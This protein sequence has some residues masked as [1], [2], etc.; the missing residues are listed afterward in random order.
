[1]K[2]II[3]EK[4][5]VAKEIAHIVG[6]DK[7]EEGYMQGNG[8]YVTWAFGHLVQPAMPDTYGMKGFHAENLPVIPDPF[9]LVP[10]QVKTE[11][12]YKPDAG[13]LAQI[14]IIGKL[15]DSSERIIVATD[16]GREGELIFRYLY[17]YLGCRKPFDRLWISSLT[18]TAIREGLLNLRDGKEYDNLYHAAKARSEADWLVGING[19]Q[20][21]TIAAGRG[22]Y[23]VGRVQ[24][25]TLGMV[26]ERYWEHKRFESKPFWQVH[27]G[28]VDADSG[29]ILKFT[30]ANRW[31]DKATATDIYNK[32]KDTGSAIITKVATKRKVE[33]APL[34]YDLTTL[35]KEANSQHG[36][37]AEHTLS[38]AQKLYEAKF[39]TYPRTSSRYISDDIFATLPKLFKNLENH[40]E[41]G[42]KVKL[43]PGSED[44][45]KNSVNAAKVTDHHALLITENPAV[46]LFKDEKIVYDMILCRMIEAFSADCIKD[47]TSV[48]AQVDHEVEFGI[49][50]SIIRQTGWRALSLKEKNNRQ[51]KDADATDNEVKDQVIPNWQEGQHITLSGCTITEGKTKPKPLHTESTL[52]AAM[53]TAGKEIED[54]T[55]RQ[56]MKD[57]GIGTPATRAAIIETLL[58]REYM[59]RQQKKLVPTEKGLALHSVVKNM[60]IANVEMTGKWEAELAK[61]ER[62]EA[63]A[64]GFT[65]SIEGYTREI[66]AELLGCD[67]LFSHKDSGCQCPKCKQGIMQFFGKVV[68]CS[69]KECGM[70]VFKQVAGKLLTDAD[71]TDL[72]TKGKTRTLN[73]FTSKQGKPFSAAIAFDE[74]FNTKF[75]FAERKTA[76]K[77]GNVK[78]YKK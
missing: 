26:C 44:Y 21:L 70:P 57:I 47:I 58:K 46:G 2:T 68:R 42:E 59:V 71:I 36:F 52:L 8:Y 69:N 73:G 43:L 12:G 4:P 18:D 20:A 76:E 33:K 19:T 39:I 63:S 28:V 41:Y 6:A 14:K 40:S 35:Q 37:T 9:V 61:I 13:V 11:N 64:D 66:T 77:R 1:M 75:V 32:V 51:D 30:S 56:S 34:L 72:L 49:S 74:N 65:H 60:A 3:A 62:G 27:F 22:T 55:M 24:T 25:P 78:R 5:S 16:A 29:N 31:A 45:S 53:E 67:R 7:R 15:F 50:G 17:A 54:D 10:R 48:S 23:S 38:I